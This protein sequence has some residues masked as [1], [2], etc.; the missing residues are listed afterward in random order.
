MT[1]DADHLERL[2]VRR[3]EIHERV[4]RG[5]V[6]ARIHLEKVRA[7]IDAIVYPMLPD[8]PVIRKGSP[9]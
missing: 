5:D 9:A 6:M 8:A 4:Q 7:E 2:K 3:R 1:S